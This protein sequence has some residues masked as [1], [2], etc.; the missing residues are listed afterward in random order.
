MNKELIEFVAKMNI[1]EAEKKDLLKFISSNLSERQF[2]LI[3]DLAKCSEKINEIK[4]D[5]N[6]YTDLINYANDIQTILLLEKK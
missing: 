6:D 4:K 5:I 2:E 3:T 1:S